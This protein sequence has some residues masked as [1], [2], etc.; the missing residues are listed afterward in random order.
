[1]CAKYTGWSN[2]AIAMPQKI[3]IGL[4]E[5]ES[6]P[7]DMTALFQ[8]HEFMKQLAWMKQEAKEAS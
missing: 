8:N 5:P 2:T 3:C 7:V 1:M 4:A 6:T